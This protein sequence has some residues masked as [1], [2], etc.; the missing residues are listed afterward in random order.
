MELWVQGEGDLRIPLAEDLSAARLFLQ[1]P[2]PDA[3]GAAVPARVE[4]GEL[5]LH[6]QAGW[7]A[8]HLFVLPG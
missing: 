1:G 7:G 4:S 6:A 8:A 2:R 3:A 5:R